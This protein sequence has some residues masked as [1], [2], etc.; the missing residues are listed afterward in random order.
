MFFN[1]KQSNKTT[2][3]EGFE[4]YDR[5]SFR[6]DLTAL[7]F[8]QVNTTDR[9]YEVY[10][11]TLAR[12][13]TYVENNP[14]EIEFIVKTMVFARTELNLRTIT[15]WL[16]FIVAPLASGK[17]YL[18][19][20]YYEILIRPDD[21]LEIVSIFNHTS[22]KIPNAL[23]RAIRDRL[24]NSWDGYQL[25]K[26]F[27]GKHAVKVP[28][29]IK[30]AH[31]TPKTTMQSTMWQNA[32]A[33]TMSNIETA[34]TVNASV[35]GDEERSKKYISMIKEGKLGYM[36]LL[37]NLK[38]IIINGIE[39]KDLA[40]VQTALT[41]EKAIKGSRI[42]PFRIAQAYEAMKETG[43]VDKFLIKRV[44]N[45][46][47]E[48]FKISV[49][50]FQI[51]PKSAKVALMLDD[52][53]SMGYSIKDPFGYGK[54][55]TA[56]VHELVGKDNS[57][58]YLWSDKA[59]QIEIGHPMEWVASTSARGG[60]TVLSL[61]VEELIKDNT[62][63]DYLFVFTDMQENSRGWSSN[64]TFAEALDRY[65]NEM[66][67]DV[68]VIFWNLAGYQGGMPV[69]RGDSNLEIVGMSDVILKLLPSLIQDKDAIFKAIEA[70]ELS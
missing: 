34:Q 9:Y 18:R 63:V 42:L 3:M 21:A 37:K 56:A 8:T 66:N 10:G 27:G 36:A 26:Y 35:V 23:R 62:V 4:S 70:L 44:L 67:K 68:K 41:L 31:P 20:A 46:L 60:G 61:A 64:E 11:D 12:V 38:H 51:V 48:A 16:A 13:Q 5:L 58:V 39:E 17:G 24:E 47:E 30:L 7:I 45:S 54:V 33:G 43:G 49:G 53:A 29:L 15:H 65:R 6:A 55:M 69:Q 40:I 50:N 32:I 28:D 19:K 22:M 52:S 14:K 57:I 2:N 25:K 59:R 1:Y